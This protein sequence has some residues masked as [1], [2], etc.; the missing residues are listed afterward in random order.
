MFF[1]LRSKRSIRAKFTIYSGQRSGSHIISHQADLIKKSLQGKKEELS[2]FIFNL[3]LNNLTY[4]QLGEN[5]CT[6]TLIF[7][8]I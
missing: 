3:I 5:L 8:L 2:N 6:F 4:F 1:L 7:G